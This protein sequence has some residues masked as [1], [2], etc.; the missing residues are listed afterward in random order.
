MQCNAMAIGKR[1]AG[2]KRRRAPR[3]SARREIA[4]VAALIADRKPC[5]KQ[6][7]PGESK[8]WHYVKKSAWNRR[9]DPIEASYLPWHAAKCDHVGYLVGCKCT[10]KCNPFEGRGG[11]PKK[12]FESDLLRRLQS[13]PGEKLKLKVYE[14]SWS[15]NVVSPNLKDPYLGVTL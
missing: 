5:D 15:F 8:E 1:R 9:L 6:C 14:I 7:E 2:L 10:H 11:Q 13:G 4:L 3:S 12:R